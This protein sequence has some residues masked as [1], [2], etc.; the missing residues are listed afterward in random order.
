MPIVLSRAFE[1]SV[2]DMH[3]NTSYFSY[4]RYTDGTGGC[5]G[6]LNWEGVGFRFTEG[7]KFKYENVH[8]T[9]NNGLGPTVE[10]LEG[11]YTDREFP[12]YLAPRLTESLQ[13]TGKL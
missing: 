10:A 4:T 13:Q 12:K 8:R 9:N 6:C 11:I 5:D 2:K 7:G 3:Y 1:F